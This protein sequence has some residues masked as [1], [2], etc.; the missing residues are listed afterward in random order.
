MIVHD[1]IQDFAG[2]NQIFRHFNILRTRERITRWMIMGDDD[3][4]GTGEN[5]FPKNLLCPYQRRVNGA[6]MDGVTADEV[7]LRIEKQDDK[8]FDFFFL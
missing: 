6:D 8:V 4:G 3:T 2:R 5:G 7:E 1:E